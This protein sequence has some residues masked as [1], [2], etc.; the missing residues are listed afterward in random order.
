[1]KRGRNMDIIQSIKM[2]LSMKSRCRGSFFEIKSSTSSRGWKIGAKPGQN[3]RSSD[4]KIVSVLCSK[5]LFPTMDRDPWSSSPITRV[6]WDENLSAYPYTNHHP[7]T[8]I[9]LVRCTVQYLGSEKQ[10]N[11]WACWGV[12]SDHLVVPGVTKHC[13]MRSISHIT[14][15]QQWG[16]ISIH[17]SLS[18][19][20]HTTGDVHGSSFWV[21]KPG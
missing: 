10:G 18:L 14:L 8:T 1:M 21:R 20:H 6:T 2:I 12:G 9:W 11:S 16:S 7:L 17:V 5:K 15:I 13:Q 3:C 4:V 19:D